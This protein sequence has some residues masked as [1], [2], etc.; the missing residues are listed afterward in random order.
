MC[1][2]NRWRL[3]NQSGGATLERLHQTQSWSLTEPGLRQLF[4]NDSLMI[5]DDDPITDSNIRGESEGQIANDKVVSAKVEQF[6]LIPEPIKGRLL[7]EKYDLS[8]LWRKMLSLA[9]CDRWLK[10]TVLLLSSRLF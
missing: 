1:V 5:P 7:T 6:K 2:C 8:L 4:E 9:V 10:C 3:S